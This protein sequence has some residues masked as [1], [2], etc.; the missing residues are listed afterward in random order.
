MY[1]F[2]FKILF[3][4][5]GFRNL[6]L[7]ETRARQFCSLI[8]FLYNRIQFSRGYPR[9]VGHNGCTRHLLSRFNNHKLYVRFAHISL[10]R[11]N[12][13]AIIKKIMEN[14]RARL[15]LLLYSLPLSYR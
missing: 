14:E 9:R 4:Q 7:G 2:F 1:S 8:A 3:Q 6:N 13:S 11:S 15:L 10:T 12:L 5:L